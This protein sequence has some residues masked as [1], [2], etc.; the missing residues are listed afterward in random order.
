[1]NYKITKN[2]T[3]SLSH[4]K[5]NKKWIL[6]DARDLVV[7]RLAAFLTHRLKGK[8]H[9]NYTAH[10]DSGD[11]IVVINCAN[12]AFTGKKEIQKLYRHH[13]GFPGGLKTRTAKQVRLSYDPCDIIRLAVKRMLGKGPMAYKRLGN[14]YLYSHSSHKQDAQAPTVIDFQSLNTKNSLVN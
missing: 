6:I 5:V 2:K 4:V 10:V 13:T 11:N 12:V 1:M 9:A 8:H 14:L 3:D 7:G